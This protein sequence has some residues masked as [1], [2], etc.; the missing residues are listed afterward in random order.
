MMPRKNRWEIFNPLAVSVN[1]CVARCV[2]K[3]F[4][5]ASEGRRT[6]MVE[7]FEELCK[8]FCIDALGM[9]F[10][11]NHVH[12]IMRNRPDVVEKLS[13]EELAERWLM[14]FP[15]NTGKSKASKKSSTDEPESDEP[16]G[17][18]VSCPTQK[19]IQALAN[20][21]KRMKAIRIRLSDISWLMRAFCQYVAV[22]ANR[23][24]EMTGRFWQGRFF[25]HPLID[26]AA[27]LACTVYV[28]LNPIRAGLAE[29]LE[30]CEHTSVLA[31][32]KALHMSRSAENNGVVE[33]D[34]NPLPTPDAFLAPIEL[35]RNCSTDPLISKTKLRASDR[36]FLPYTVEQYIELLRF[37]ASMSIK[38]MVEGE[39]KT[40]PSIL[41]SLN[42][43]IDTWAQVFDPQNQI[44]RRQRNVE[45]NS[46]LS[47][48]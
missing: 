7:R 36:G 13:N 26:E 5:I 6:W 24:D 25:S 2:R 46:I 14:I 21:K 8:H 47:P 3:E 9:A 23:E 41:A 18:P 37:S 20:D 45:L 48:T 38:S 27:I 11:S 16:L 42:I 30:E 32:I 33:A 19:A 12:L 1:H 39:T 10:L 17:K 43:S 35:D 28:D 34:S 15:G 22:R 40:I 44:F 4:L 29:S 31:R